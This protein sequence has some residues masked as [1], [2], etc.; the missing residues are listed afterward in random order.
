MGDSLLY[1]K[2]V[3][4]PTL[5]RI[6]KITQLYKWKKTVIC[7]LKINNTYNLIYTALLP[8]IVSQFI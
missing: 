7:C 1:F 3:L 6:L 4:V 5:F 8:Q 2:S